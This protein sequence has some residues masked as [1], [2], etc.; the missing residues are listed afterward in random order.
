MNRKIYLIAIVGLLISSSFN[1]ILAEV[2][3]ESNKP[4]D[5]Q[6]ITVEKKVFDGSEWVDVVDANLG[7]IVRFNITVSYYCND[8]NHSYKQTNITVKDTLPDCLEFADN[9]TMLY[10]SNV[11][12]GYTYK[13]ED[14]KTIWWNL[15]AS[16]NSW[17]DEDI[18]LG[19]ISDNPDM[20]GSVSI[21]FDAKVINYTDNDGEKNIVDVNAWEYC[22]NINVYGSSSATVNV[23][24]EKTIIKEFT[25]KEWQLFSLPFGS[26]V[27]KDELIVRYNNTDYS[28]NE[29][30][31][32]GIILN[33]I[34]QFDNINKRW[35]TVDELSP[36]L[37][38]YTYIYKENVTLYAIG[39]HPD[40]NQLITYIFSGWNYIGIR[41]S[42]PVD[43]SDLRF[44]YNGTEYNLDEAANQSIVLKFIYWYN[45]TGQVHIIDDMLFPGSTY[46]MYSYKDNVT[47]S[48]NS[49]ENQPPDKPVNPWPYDGEVIYIINTNE[50]NTYKVKLSVE[51]SDPDGDLLTVSF[52][53]DCIDG[54]Q[55]IGI[56]ID[57]VH[58]SGTAYVVWNDLKPGKY[59]WY[60]VADDG[61]QHTHS[62]IFSFTL[63][64]TTG[65]N[66][67]PDKPVNPK[68]RDGE[69]IYDTH[70]ITLS[71]IVSDPDDDNMSV[72]FF[73]ASDDSVI[74]VDN[75][76]ASG[77]SALVYWNDLDYGTTY[78]W[79]AIAYD[80]V[81]KN[82]SEIFS[83]SLKEKNPP[84][85]HIKLKGKH[86]NNG[87]YVSNVIVELDATDDETGVK[88][89]WYA[90]DR[91][92][93][94]LYEKPF[95]LEKE[96]NRVINY[97][98]IDESGNVEETKTTEIHIDKTLPSTEY[99]LYG[100]K[101]NENTY[102]NSVKVELIANDD[103]SGVNFI[104]Y[105]ILN[106]N[107][108]ENLKFSIYDEV[109]VIDEP[110][111]NTVEFYSTD[112]AGNKEKRKTF[113]IIIEDENQ[114]ATPP[115]TT[116]SLTGNN[117]NNNWFRSNVKVTLTAKD[118][119]SGVAKTYYSIN[120][121]FTT[122]YTEPFKISHEGKNTLSYYS[123]D[124]AGNKE[125]NKEIEIKIDRKKPST[126]Y[127]IEGGELLKTW[128][129]NGIPVYIYQG[130]V[131]II[132]E[133]SDS[134]SGVDKTTYAIN[135]GPFLLYKNPF[136]LRKEGK[137]VIHYRSSDKAGNTEI[138]KG[139]IIHIVEQERSDEGPRG[140][141]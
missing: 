137:Y 37:G 83:F 19:N 140:P 88:E 72:T 44:T 3:P 103:V 120:S 129:E 130:E 93:F 138:T 16:E 75:N 28:F 71:V 105:R 55:L 50:D 29:A 134:T 42:E 80:G 136:G 108:D 13:S 11:Y 86:G 31:S 25:R 77:S 32:E 59:S 92:S 67:P 118:E 5:T 135:R 52:Y 106:S 76:V 33:F 56:G 53:K 18:E 1:I 84:E 91:G 64:E 24:C 102:E 89:T 110:G 49:D 66:N 62:D 15:T 119:E 73:D 125:E 45:E 21:Y 113:T 85:T 79:Y 81:F 23:L 61:L 36:G 96:G 114:D 104:M 133:A 98:S 65:E 54:S 115:V 2:H 35:N 8:L 117:G 69:T 39:N 12:S 51:V 107:N 48:I 41:R 58:G 126:E 27:T 70:E 20:I 26:S 109:F 30:S 139:F 63:K 127:Y 38:H 100:E 74:G 43:I 57:E 78:S 99:I 141:R 116:H 101:I 87:W 90:I 17:L 95:L 132:L 7:D 68:P 131:I 60:A 47:V 6:I 34:Y 14:N 121:H 82:K 10:G 112:K 97:Y 124:K 122:V 9:I 111:R 40:E 22:T 46:I 4:Y 94:I 123:I 128:S